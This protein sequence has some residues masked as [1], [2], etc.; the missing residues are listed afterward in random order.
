MKLSLNKGWSIIKII[1]YLYIYKDS[2]IKVKKKFFQDKVLL[3]SK[4]ILDGYFPQMSLPTEQIYVIIRT[5][6]SIKS[7]VDIRYIG[8]SEIDCAFILS[9]FQ[10]KQSSEKTMGQSLYKNI[11]LLLG[12]ILYINGH[13]NGLRMDYLVFMTNENYQNRVHI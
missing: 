4:R 12:T 2:I 7:S 6:E 13:K 1:L 10:S 5:P 11:K 9:Q 3:S 8:C